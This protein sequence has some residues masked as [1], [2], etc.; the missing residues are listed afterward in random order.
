MHMAEK[1]KQW[2]EFKAGNV[3]ICGDSRCVV[4]ELDPDDV[5]PKHVPLRLQ[6]PE[7]GKES[8]FFCAHQT[9]IKKATSEHG[10]Y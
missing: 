8:A 9:K 4:I 7:V 6:V 2:G 10:L 5:M 1:C 3:V